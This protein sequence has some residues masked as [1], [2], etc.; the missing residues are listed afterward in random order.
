MRARGRIFSQWAWVV[1]A[2]FL[3][4]AASAETRSFPLA[5]GE[6]RLERR[7]EDTEVFFRALRLNRATDQWNVDVTVRNRG[8]RPLT[9][10]VLLRFEAPGDTAGVAKPDGV[11]P[12]G[13]AF[14]DLT[15]RLAKG[16]LAAGAEL[17][18]FTLVLVKTARAPR[19]D[20]VVFA[21][22]AADAVAGSG[23]TRTLDAIGLPLPGVTAEG[24]VSERGGWLTFT[25]GEG[26]T[27]SRFDAPGRLPVF[28]FAATGAGVTELPPPR[29]T[30]RV[31]DDSTLG[32]AK[33][34]VT[35]L[36]P[37]TLTAPLPLG[38]SPLAAAFVEFATEPAAPVAT[39]FTPSAAVLPVEQA[40]LVRWDAA[41]PA[42]EVVSLVAGKGTDPVPVTLPGSGAF[43]L[44]VPDAGVPAA[45]AG[46][47]LPASPLAPPAEQR[48]AATGKVMPASRPASSQPEQVTTM[49][50]V[51][52]RS[53]VG[54]LPSGV[55]LRCA[56]REEY[57]L[58][59]GSRRV[60]PR[61]ETFVTGHQ[62]PGDT[63]AGTLTASFPL[64][65][66]LLLPGE[67][68]GEAKLTVEV[69]APGT[70]TGRLLTPAGGTLSDGDVR[71]VALADVFATPQAA[72]LTALAPP[73]L[74]GVATGGQALV[75]AFEL[76]LAG[77]RAGRRLL[78]AFAAQ[79][80]G[81]S[82]VL[83]RTVFTEGL[84]G[85]QPVERFV[86]DAAGGLSS[87]EPTSGERLPGI[88]G[89]GQYLLLQA[90]A[91]SALVSGVARDRAGRPAAGLAV[92]VGPWLAF[93]DPTGRYQALAPGGVSE[94]TISDPRTGDIGSAGVAVAS[95]LAAVSADLD[96]LP[97]G[98]R[99][100]AVAP[101]D[102]S[103]NVARVSSVVVTFSKPLDPSRLVAP[104]AVQ[105]L[106]TNGL[107]LAASVSA[108]LARTVVTLLPTAELPP[109]QRLTLRFAAGLADATGLPLEGPREFHFTTQSDLLVR[110]D[111]QLVI[112]EPVDGM[113]LM[114]GG[115][116]MAEPES[117][118]ILVNETSG[119][120]ATVLSKPDGSLANSIP[121]EVDDFLSVVLVN[122]NGTRNTLPASRQIFRDGRIGLY[123]GGGTIEVE[124]G[125][126]PVQVIVDPGA[127]PGKTKI[128]LTAL[129]A[130]QVLA[131]AQGQA[132]TAGQ[133]IGGLRYEETGDPLT[134]AAHVAVP[135]DEAAL[136]LP[137]GIRPEDGAY[138]LVMPR[139]VEGTVVYEIAD[140]MR[141]ERTADGRARL[142][143]KSPPFVGLLMQKLR[144]QAEASKRVT[145]P[146]E[147]RSAS[148]GNNGSVS[149]E[150]FGVITLD[151]S[152][153]FEI[154]GKVVSVKLDASNTPVGTPQPVAGA[155]VAVDFSGV[156]APGL[157]RAGEVIST[158]DLGGHFA[159]FYRP[160]AGGIGRE[161]SASHPR[162][163]FQIARSPGILFNPGATEVA[164]ITLRFGEPF[165]AATGVAGDGAP[166]VEVSSTPTLPVPGSAPDRG[167]EVTVIGVDDR[168][169]TPP[170][171]LLLK[172]EDFN[173]ERLPAS[174]VRI[175]QASELR[176]SPAR[177]VVRFR[178][179]CSQRARVTVV[180]RV[181][182][183]TGQVTQV[184]HPL[185]FGG[186]F[187]FI[188]TGDGSDRRGPRLVLSWPPADSGFI[189]SL[190]PI[191][192]K[193]NEPLASAWL[194]PEH[195][196]DWLDF[197]GGHH[198]IGVTASADRRE[199]VIRYDG[200]V[201][202]E[203]RLVVGPPLSDDQGN[204]FDADSLTPGNQGHTLQFIQTGQPVQTLDDLG[205]DLAQGGGVVFQGAF[206]Y[207]LE[208]VGGEVGRLLSF[209]LSVPSKPTVRDS[210]ELGA[211]PTTLAL[212]PSLPLRVG[213]TVVD[214]KA[215]GGE[216][217]NLSFVAVFTGAANDLKQLTLVPSVGDLP[218]R[219]DR[220][221][222]RV[223][224]SRSEAAQIVKSKWDAPFLGY[225]ELGGDVTS[226][227]LLDLNATYLFATDAEVRRG[228]PRGGAPGNDANGDGNYC[229]EGEFPPLPAS[230]GGIVPGL[231]FSYAPADPDERLQDFDFASGAGQVAVVTASRAGT[232]PGTF[233]LV[234]TPGAED[235]NEAVVKFTGAE[236]PKRVLLLPAQRTETPTGTAVRDLALV[237]LLTE[238]DGVLAVVDLT[239]PSHPFLARRLQ[240]PA[241]EGTPGTIIPRADGRLALATSANVLLL[242]PT[243]LLVAQTTLTHPAFV[244][245]VAGLGGGVR[246]FVADASGVNVVNSGANHRVV[247][248][249]PNF[250]FV[251][252][253]GAV[254]ARDEI[255]ALPPAALA[256]KLSGA[257]PVN[258]A[259]V[260]RFDFEGAP[261]VADPRL[262]YYVV[263]DIPGGAGDEVPLILAST[264]GRGKPVRT[265]L[266]DAVPY[267]IGDDPTV[268]LTVLRK[269]ADG[270]EKTLKFAEAVDNLTQLTEGKGTN[271]LFDS[272]SKL[273]ETAQEQGGSLET[274]FGI[275]KTQFASYP[276][277]ISARRLSDD[278][279]SALYNRYL[280]GPFVLVSR[281]VGEARLVALQKQVS[282]HFLR[283]GSFV[284]AGLVP[285]LV[286]NKTVGRY[287]SRIFADGQPIDFDLASLPT[288]DDVL[289]NVALGTFGG[290][291]GSK[292]ISK[293]LLGMVVNALGLNLNFRPVAVPG[294]N[295]LLPVAYQERPLVFVPGFG[296]SHL[297][298]SLGE[299]NEQG[300]A[301]GGELFPGILDT[302]GKMRLQVR[303]DGESKFEVSVPDALRKVE[304]D[305]LGKKFTLSSIYAPL[306]AYITGELGYVEYDF[307]KPRVRGDLFKQ[308]QAERR[309]LRGKPNLT[310]DP[311][312]NFFVFPYDWRLDDAAAGRQ[313]ADYIDLALELHPEADG[314]DLVAHSNGGLVSRSYM[315]AHPDT[316][317]RFIS[318]GTPWLGLP[319]TLSALRTG[320]LGEMELDFVVPP[321]LMRKGVQFM[322]AVHQL[323]PSRGYFDLGF[324]PV[325]ELGHD[326][327]GN[328]VNFEAYGYPAYAEALEKFLFRET[329]ADVGFT[330][331]ISP[332]RAN[333]EAFQRPDAGLP[334]GD[335]RKDSDRIEVHHIFGMQAVP[336]T[337]G[338][339]R[340]R[341]R[342]DLADTNR[343]MRTIELPAP[344]FFESEQDH[345]PAA[346]GFPDA[347]G[348]LPLTGRQFNLRVDVELGRVIGD[349]TVPIGSLS[350]GAGSVASLNAPHAQLHP[351]ISASAFA[352]KLSGHNDMLANPKVLELLS[353]LLDGVP[354]AH[355]DAHIA[356]PGEVTEGQA[357]EFRGLYD[358]PPG[359]KGDVTFIWDFGDGT[360][361]TRTAPLHADV[362]VS[363]KFRQ[364]GKHL[365]SLGVTT[366][367]GLSGYTSRLVTVAN[368]K[369]VVEIEGGDRTVPRGRLVFYTARV[370][371]PGLD[372]Q[373]VYH[374]FVDGR[375]V[376]AQRQFVAG[377]VLDGPG[378]HQLKVVVDDHDG[379]TNVGLA[380]ITA[381]AAAVIP[382]EGLGGARSRPRLAGEPLV[383]QGGHPQLAVHVRGQKLF[384]GDPNVSVSN[385]GVL[386][387]GSV[388]NLA[389]TAGVFAKE[390]GTEAGV[391][392]KR[393]YD[394]AVAD[395]SS[396]DT[397]AITVFRRIGPDGSLGNDAAISLVGA[398]RNLNLELTY[399][400]GGVVRDFY[401][402]SLFVSN[403]LAVK[404]DWD[405]VTS[406][407]VLR[408][409]RTTDR[410]SRQDKNQLGPPIPPDVARFGDTF[411]ATR[412]PPSLAAFVN[413]ANDRVLLF[414]REAAPPSPTNRPSLFL[415]V[416]RA[417]DGRLEDDI[418]F[419]LSSTNFLRTRLPTRPFALVARDGLGNLTPFDTF[420]LNQSQD[421]TLADDDDRYCQRLDRIRTAVL[422]AM[423]NAVDSPLVRGRFLLAPEHLWVFE[424]GSGACLWKPD[425]CVECNGNYVP[426]KSDHDYQL[427]LPTQL[428]QPFALTPEDRQR[429]FA[430]GTHD[431]ATLAGDWYF[432]RPR[433]I[434]ADGQET[435]DQAAA[436]RWL[437]DLPTGFTTTDGDRFIEVERRPDFTD[438]TKGFPE[439]LT[440]AEVL[441]FTFTAAVR[442]DPATRA[443]L[444]EVSF[445]PVHREH[446]MFGALDLEL[447][448]PFGDDPLGDAGLGRQLLLLK[449]ALE[450]SFVPFRHHGVNDGPPANPATL[451]TIY[452]NVRDQ[453]VPRAEGYE[454]GLLQHYGALS[455]KPLLDIDV[456]YGSEGIKHLG[457]S[458]P[459]PAL[460]LCR[461]DAITALQ[462]RKLK[463]LGKAG[464]RA[465]LARLVAQAPTA[466]L[467]FALGREGYRAKGLASFEDYIL[468]T[469]EDAKVG[470]QVFGEFGRDTDDFPELRD[471]LEAKKGDDALLDRVVNTPGGYRRF[472][473]RTFEFLRQQV[474]APS[475]P[476]YREF[477]SALEQDNQL[478]EL[479]FRRE[480]AHRL[481]HGDG[482]RIK[483]I[484]K[485]LE[486]ADDEP[487]DLAVQGMNFA[488]EERD[489][490]FRYDRTDPPPAGPSRAGRPRLADLPSPVAIAKGEPVVLGRP[491]ERTSV[492]D[493]DP[494]EPR[495]HEEIVNPTETRIMLESQDVTDP[496][497]A[498][499]F[500]RSLRS[501]ELGPKLPPP[502]LTV[503][504]NNQ[505]TQLTQWDALPDGHPASPRIMLTGSDDLLIQVED[506]EGLPLPLARLTTTSQPAPLTV[507]LREVKPGVY[508]N[509]TAPVGITGTP[510]RGTP[511]EL[512]IKD[513][514]PL[515]IELVGFDLPDGRA[516]RRS[517]MVDRAE[518]ATGGLTF[519]SS[520][521][522]PEPRPTVRGVFDRM[523]Y[524]SAGDVQFKDDIETEGEGNGFARFI[525]KFGADQ[526]DDGE[527]DVL[528]S[529]SHGNGSGALSG[530]DNANNSP[531]GAFLRP[532][533]DLPPW[534]SHDADYLILQA[535]SALSPQGLPAGEQTL[536][537]LETW[538]FALRE[539]PKPPHMILG[540][541]KPA[542]KGLQAALTEFIENAQLDPAA[543]GSGARA[544]WKAAMEK[545][546]S[547]IV[548]TGTAVLTQPWAV[549]YFGDKDDA[550]G[551]LRPAR[552]PLPTDQ[553]RFDSSDPL[554]PGSAENC[555]LGSSSSSAGRPAA[556]A[557]TAN[558]PTHAPGALVVGDLTT[559]R[560]DWQRAGWR[561]ELGRHWVWRAGAGTR[562]VA[563]AGLEPGP[564]GE[565]LLRAATDLL[566]ARR[567]GW[568]LQG[569]A[570][571]LS[572]S[573]DAAGRLQ[574][575]GAGYTANFSQEAA[576]H[577]VLGENLV[578]T[579]A[580]D[581]LQEI[582]FE[583]GLLVE[584]E[585]Q[586]VAPLVDPSTLSPKSPAGRQKAVVEPSLAQLPSATFC[587]VRPAADAA[588]EVARLVPAW[589]FDFAP[590][591]AAA[592]DG[593]AAPVQS[594]FHHA[595]TGALLRVA[596]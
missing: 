94:V 115:A 376:P 399:G 288:T 458:L 490:I 538:S 545:P 221:T 552:D 169:V 273:F 507:Q 32:G 517:I 355:L 466:P 398:D 110:S 588:S 56:I 425:S 178:V 537:G 330:N 408:V 111:A 3:G 553:L 544:A 435:T 363:H 48:W 527:A 569:L 116:G 112:H 263:A 71:L 595:V 464:I 331:A 427:F 305:L 590:S 536:R 191:Q 69:L 463:K 307:V 493:E 127:V 589:R 133:L 492:A 401:S 84:Y 181:T 27:V 204:V 292:E 419:E 192:L 253:S 353:T 310:Q 567:T 279:A 395:L 586:A 322:P 228:A 311:T 453:G 318:V 200:P 291:A 142:I 177:T 161:L 255:A 449:W 20:A 359:T 243:L 154:A 486:E 196:A 206:A 520:L 430:A 33:A 216:C 4:V 437:Y 406:T 541:F 572:G 498:G 574:P 348:A 141:F 426:G 205:R 34:R 420:C 299:V 577:P 270:I 47:A 341:P 254:Q 440:P 295:A 145:L 539:S 418:F 105:L 596:P 109:K 500:I 491:P 9:G 157:L 403:N 52:F 22:A 432:R 302:P 256:V 217:T 53:T 79:T 126:G 107:A 293:K 190:S 384:F 556:L 225:L 487:I 555:E 575:D 113:A 377:L 447:P 275:W 380:T 44:V 197:A 455:A 185:L 308:I 283:A 153:G 242:D 423:T 508:R 23:V 144:A 148:T 301:D 315:L 117:P 371:D 104:G 551:F 2:S 349:G 124:G 226:L 413:P 165:A 583:G 389:A 213:V 443:V 65:P 530:H 505:R 160:S 223:L 468:R 76:D 28:R 461:E 271:T 156:R 64:R 130:E 199:L 320:D 351:V 207:A 347:D 501:I 259:Q 155:V 230:G 16:Q 18:P 317:K 345:P 14:I 488:G 332:V 61:Y 39:E 121:A 229:G 17:P 571:N 189:P 62:R 582:R 397:A 282:R 594:V 434:K 296:G 316:V 149:F 63:D 532:L 108:N 438:L 244:G 51:V 558:L 469:I 394:H 354:V 59:D 11:D 400:E 78:P 531:G 484:N 6:V 1:V 203:V 562:S 328:G 215:S 344:G 249:P 285:T 410:V 85:L 441:A 393:L 35:P 163:P 415:A 184:N 238:G 518:Y 429:F 304:L 26:A 289:L 269:V 164:N 324:R 561:L 136:R 519:G 75:A 231:Q 162:F 232:A 267:L 515:T 312:P 528:Y 31:A 93:T 579:V 360:A 576:G 120:T 134:V 451:D 372:D 167:A 218:G 369:P 361:E 132:P 396:A 325:V 95:D 326:L 240:L 405:W 86:S 462:K 334:I 385:G 374:W 222:A 70:F 235:L 422:G 202:G 352:D 525:R 227:S 546:R 297:N 391:A 554:G 585:P 504:V 42:W 265:K 340:L 566:P 128:R 534:V 125:G 460:A 147:L 335:W 387:F 475:L 477:L 286:E 123:A 214:G 502:T 358:A 50:Q 454:W 281:D 489:F 560:L 101:A 533:L 82:F 309:S 183:S 106:D 179:E 129:P 98:P 457:E 414:A 550:E 233:R 81:A 29:L 444:P 390:L 592:S 102:G 516:F 77:V 433:F 245:V 411:A 150:V 381:S 241:G 74:A 479:G 171:L 580:D 188:P 593:Y 524:F 25:G 386:A 388:G 459:G 535:C 439:P 210:L 373:H 158:S 300:G 382:P 319:K 383:A 471:F 88:D 470:E 224:L 379:G 67:E 211:W 220:R 336:N 151:F 166:G 416:D 176:D 497:V 68:L 294:A 557:L 5:G 298:F 467:A 236:R 407:P 260:A 276:L 342:L 114:T 523:A 146:G 563:T 509:D 60:P 83:A 258:A 252:F 368:A 143:T 212:I 87:V 343:S 482:G 91:R 378:E 139:N 264:D 494:G 568:R 159:F 472:V 237:S 584:P 521:Q 303:P 506:I 272:V 287:A 49:A 195:W 10:L 481:L 581:R 333:H 404:V 543:G 357:A 73:D 542:I 30:S 186:A 559:A 339:L 201:D 503:F 55:A 262:H 428:G 306:F 327:N 522:G 168:E 323:L 526:P 540:F 431:P 573:V 43:A 7:A 456:R 137:P 173:G 19:V 547:Y 485:L 402:W 280:A 170:A 54:A 58:R 364:D 66:L 578:V 172:A 442:D 40:V 375:A 465:A 72:R 417:G 570:R 96:T 46:Q 587:W 12:E 248:T 367:S 198:V 350:R 529:L 338:Q 314:V 474:Q 152:S 290:D 246:D 366:A 251:T 37:Q 15:P 549:L 346:V 261:P 174:V 119:F 321:E 41:R 219:L 436:A 591:T 45:V 365:V 266:K 548:S 510:P 99:V 370:R 97:H 92:R 277:G 175:I 512:F 187:P 495:L 209:D 513:E 409:S 499:I 138:A 514:E 103:V 100:L 135:V 329:H 452:A 313:L 36:T 80:P 480:N 208:R 250:R 356:D 284:W 193:F 564:I 483:G 140:R 392:I 122:R 473:L 182:D 274:L 21:T 38:W 278:P 337:I 478:A 118:V 421:F 194:E 247:Q 362:T 24:V 234:L 445:F 180:A 412:R 424:Q 268:V 448:P 476:D 89:G 511:T 239:D 257:H 446:F 57:L 13:K 131:F 565:A 8:P 450:G 496:D 90:P